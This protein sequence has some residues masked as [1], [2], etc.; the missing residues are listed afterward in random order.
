VL[1]RKDVPELPRLLLQPGNRLRVGDLALAVR[2][3]P[4]QRRISGCERVD[5]GVEM[6]RLRHLS[7]HRECDQA[8]D[9]GNEHDCNP[10]QSD[11]TVDGWTRG[12]TDGA[13]LFP[14]LSETNGAM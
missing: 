9:R 12:A 3:L 14:A 6:P 11:W 1:A 2:D 13:V 8:A 5:L 4:R 7:V 10:A